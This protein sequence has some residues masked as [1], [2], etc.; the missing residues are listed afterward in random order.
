M[1]HFICI[2]SQYFINTGTM[3]KIIHALHLENGPLWNIAF[4]NLSKHKLNIYKT[5]YIE[6][7]SILGGVESTFKKNQPE[8]SSLMCIH[9]VYA[10]T[11]C[12]NI[13]TD[14]VP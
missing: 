14:R 4:F 13:K 7:I 6:I 8:L 3:K 9:S 1:R 5:K 2:N 12:R 10:T 11:L